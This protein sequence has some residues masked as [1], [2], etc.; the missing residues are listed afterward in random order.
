MTMIEERVYTHADNALSRTAELM[1][2]LQDIRYDPVG[3]KEEDAESLQKVYD[4]L[5][6][7]LEY[8][9]MAEGHTGKG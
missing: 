1:R 6:Q 5:G 2:I 4:I 7:A 9:H 3:G 8:A